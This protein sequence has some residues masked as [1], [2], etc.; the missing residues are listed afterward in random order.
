VAAHEWGDEAE[1]QKGEEA[2]EGHALPGKAGGGGFADTSPGQSAA[3]G[4]GRS[5]RGVSDGTTAALARGPPELR[6]G[7]ARCEVGWIEGSKSI[8][9]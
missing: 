5:R 8:P 9:G 7:W 6:R 1:T 4:A 2:G 3:L